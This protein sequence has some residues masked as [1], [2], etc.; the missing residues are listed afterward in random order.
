MRYRRG[1]VFIDQCTSREPIESEG[2]IQGVRLI[3][4]YG[5]RENVA[6]AGCRLEATS[7]PATVKIKALHRRL[8]NDGAGIRA[9]INDAAPLP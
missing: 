3:V 9:D 1:A 6:R 5:V 4:R 7:T 8:A 2:C